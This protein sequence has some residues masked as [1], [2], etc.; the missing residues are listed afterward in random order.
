MR[1]MEIKA[2]W[3][4]A[5]NNESAPPL[6][7]GRRSLQVYNNQCFIYSFCCAWWQGHQQ[8]G[9][10]RQ[11]NDI[12]WKWFRRLPTGVRVP[13]SFGDGEDKRKQIF[14][15]LLPSG[16]AFTAHIINPTEFILRHANI[17]HTFKHV[18]RPNLR[19]VQLKVSH[20]ATIQK[21]INYL[22]PCWYM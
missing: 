11:E 2:F 18:W 5:P 15:R 13:V 9:E 21:L 10:C 19:R 16:S 3:R 12:S 6:C 8:T 22:L 4:T 20:L 1:K 14:R 7:G 17:N